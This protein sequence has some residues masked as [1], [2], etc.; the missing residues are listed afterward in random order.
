MMWQT[1]VETR[2][3]PRVRGMALK[4]PDR[5]LVVLDREARVDCTPTL[6]AQCTLVLAQALAA[7][8]IACNLRVVVCDRKFENA[9]FADVSI[10]DHLQIVDP[11]KKF[12]AQ[13]PANID[14]V[15][16]LAKLNDCIAEGKCYDKLL[17]GLALARKLNYDNPD[18]LQKSRCL[19][20]LISEM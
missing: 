11:N 15:N 9:I 14:G 10:V 4:A 2:V 12:S 3:F 20:K 17:H 5:V 16:V 18:V 13:V 8:N 6:A 19:R 1:L 7:E